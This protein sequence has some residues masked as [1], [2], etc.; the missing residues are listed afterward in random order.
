[1]NWREYHFPYLIHDG[2]CYG[3][4]WVDD[5]I[6]MTICR[7]YSEDEP[8]EIEVQFCGVEWARCT[9]AEE[10]PYDSYD[11]RIPISNYPMIEQSEFQR[12]YK[13]FLAYGNL[14]DICYLDQNIV[15]IDDIMII[16]CHEIKIIRAVCNPDIQSTIT[17]IF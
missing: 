4:K 17:R 10:E 14:N 5:I 15:F 13:K 2:A 12:D 11:S 7:Y 1:M 6:S 9:C 8:N 16:K 3:A